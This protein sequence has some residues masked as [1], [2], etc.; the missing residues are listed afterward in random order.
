[1]ASKQLRSSSI[2]QLLSILATGIVATIVFWS[3][4]TDA[5]QKV[6]SGHGLDT[7]ETAYLDEYNP[8]G[9]LV[10]LTSFGIALLVGAALRI[11]DY[12]E[13][14]SL[15]QKYGIRKPGA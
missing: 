9:F 11:R 6:A 15:E 14:R 10:L 4:F 2:W 7:S 5:I 8:I 1:M 3:A 13:V 12:L